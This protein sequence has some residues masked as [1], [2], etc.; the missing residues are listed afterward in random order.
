[1]PSQF[2]VVLLTYKFSY[3]LSGPVFLSFLDEVWNQNIGPFGPRCAWYVGASHQGFVSS[4]GLEALNS[5]YSPSLLKFLTGAASAQD[6]YECV[7]VV[8]W[9]A[10]RDERVGGPSDPYFP[11]EDNGIA[12]CKQTWQYSL[13][14]DPYCDHFEFDRYDLKL[15]KD[16]K[17]ISSRTE[18]VAPFTVFGD[19]DS[20]IRG[21]E[22]EVGYY[23]LEAVGYSGP[24]VEHWDV[25]DVNF[26]FQ[27]VECAI[28]FEASSY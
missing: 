13:S 15:F 19:S 18:R 9:N 24:P 28:P 27:V 1:L 22:M 14:V 8:F 25:L 7:P 20:D 3:S 4:W 21:R 16:G 12:L 17:L 23:R 26:D 11:S 10:D 2:A 6:N 5:R